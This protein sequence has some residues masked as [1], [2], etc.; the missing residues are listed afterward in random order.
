MAEL[1]AELIANLKAE[2]A[3]STPTNDQL[4]GAHCGRKSNVLC[5]KFL[6]YGVVRMRLEQIARL[7]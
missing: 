2:R 7:P 5:A 1:E 3:E 4:I 6:C